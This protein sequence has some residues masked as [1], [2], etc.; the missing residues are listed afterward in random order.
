MFLLSF[1]FYCDFVQRPWSDSVLFTA[2]NKL[3]IWL[4]Y[5]TLH[6]LCDKQHNITMAPWTPSA[7]SHSCGRWAVSEGGVFRGGVSE[8]GQSEATEHHLMVCCGAGY[9][10][11]GHYHVL[12]DIS[13]QPAWPRDHHSLLAY[14]LTSQ[15]ILLQCNELPTRRSAAEMAVPTYDTDSDW[16]LLKQRTKFKRQKKRELVMK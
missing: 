4:L 15:H 11:N 14:I 5:I 2:L 12:A 6:T 8:Y 3:T 13:F 10:D 7:Y 1:L 9:S 16:H